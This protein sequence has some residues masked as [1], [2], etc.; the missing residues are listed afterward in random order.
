MQENS[1]K[2][3][4]LFG[5]K[6]DTHTVIQFLN[7]YNILFDMVSARLIQ[8]KMNR[9]RPGYF[10]WMS[11]RKEPDEPELLSGVFE[12]RTLGTPLALLVRK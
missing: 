8:E 4:F 12:D 6:Y 2:N 7:Y 11:A 5:L 3:H 10:P 9:R 1:D